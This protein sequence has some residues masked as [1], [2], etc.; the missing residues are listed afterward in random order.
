MTA[1]YPD[2]FVD[3]LEL[4]WGAGYMSPGGPAEVVRIVQQAGVIPPGD[5]LD[6][7]MG[8]GGP[9]ITLIQDAGANSVTGVDVEEPVIARARR[10]I[11]RA[12]LDSKIQAHLAISDEYPFSDESFDIAFSKDS[13]LHIQDKGAL[14]VEII[15]LLKQNGHLVFSDWLC[16][17]DAEKKPEFIK[18]NQLTHL[19]IRWQTAQEV[20][21]QLKSAGFTEIRVSEQMDPYIKSSEIELGYIRGK[22]KSKFMDIMDAETFDKFVAIKAANL[23][24]ARSGALRPTHVCCMK[25]GGLS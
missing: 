4:M 11:S 13:M 6:I 12:G 5:V 3:R 15:R 14:Y 17:Q 25:P 20:V 1:M 2:T 10:N 7:G 16:S 23:N 9:A 22:L 8:I 21:D 24:A 18:Y 19:E